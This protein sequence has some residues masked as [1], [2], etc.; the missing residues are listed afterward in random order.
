MKH[1]TGF[2]KGLL[3]WSLLFLIAAEGVKY[4][5]LSARTVKLI[6][7]L[8]L[9]LAIGTGILVGLADAFRVKTE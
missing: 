6:G 4:L 7:L 8:E 1:L 5:H 3:A 9:I 2:Q